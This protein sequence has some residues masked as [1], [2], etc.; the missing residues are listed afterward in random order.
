MNQELSSCR[1]TA[2]G[3]AE[4]QPQVSAQ[5]HRLRWRR[6]AHRRR[7]Q[8]TR[9]RSVIICTGEQALA[10]IAAQGTYVE[11]GGAL[12]QRRAAARARIHARRG[13]LVV[14][15]RPR[16]LGALLAQDPEL[17]WHERRVSVRLPSTV[18][19][20]LFLIEHGAPFGLGFL[21]GRHI[22]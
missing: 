2:P 6:S 3:I 22:S 21:N 1:V 18:S 19:A 15:T 20:Y 10:R 4:R 11:L 7:M 8:A 9:N 12:V 5:R 17:C 14:L 13:V 16:G